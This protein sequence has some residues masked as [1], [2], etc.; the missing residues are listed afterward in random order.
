[1][2]HLFWPGGYNEKQCREQ[3][4]E[5][6]NTS[7][8]SVMCRSFIIEKTFLM[9]LFSDTLTRRKNKDEFEVANIENVYHETIS[10]ER[11]M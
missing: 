11:T 7:D 6:S 2:C 8:D 3:I 10:Y 9:S 5:N 4:S 1:M